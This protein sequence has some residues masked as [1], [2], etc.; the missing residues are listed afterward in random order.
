MPVVID[1]AAVPAP[2]TS[3]FGGSTRSQKTKVQPVMPHN[4]CRQMWNY[5]ECSRG[6][7]CKYDHKRN[8]GQ[9]GKTRSASEPPKGTARTTGPR[10]SPALAATLHK[11]MYPAIACKFWTTN[12]C[13]MGHKCHFSHSH[14]G[15]CKPGTA[16]PAMPVTPTPEVAQGTPPATPATPSKTS[17]RK[18]AKASGAG[19]DPYNGKPVNGKACGCTFNYSVPNPAYDEWIANKASHAKLQRGDADGFLGR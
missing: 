14:P 16:M 18:A 5:G 1:P 11:P 8:P 19:F 9:Q 15:G 13:T 4:A 3:A 7:D 6:D 2:P 17:V 12:S 10:R